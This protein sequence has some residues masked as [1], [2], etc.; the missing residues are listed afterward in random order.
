VA[1]TFFHG[2]PRTGMLTLIGVFVALPI[3]GSIVFYLWP[4][5]PMGRSLVMPPEDATVAA[6]PVLLELEQLRG[7]IGRTVSPMRPAGVVD[8]D[9]RR[10]DCMTEGLMVDAGQWVKCIE[11]KAGK[12]VVRQIEKPSLED[13]ES[14]DLA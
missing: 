10:V 7:R 4:R 13:L 14:T 5:T 8:F 1:L 11:V 12:V 9:G 2:E 6:M 3:L